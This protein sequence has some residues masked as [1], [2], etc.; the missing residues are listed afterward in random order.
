MRRT[1]DFQNVP[2]A[3][4]PSPPLPSPPRPTSILD[5]CSPLP[6]LCTKCARASA[7]AISRASNHAPGDVSWY[8]LSTPRVHTISSTIDP[9]ENRYLGAIEDHAIPGEGTSPPSRCTFEDAIVSR[10]KHNTHSRPTYTSLFALFAV[11]RDIKYQSKPEHP[12]AL[13]SNAIPALSAR[14]QPALEAHSQP[15]TGS[16]PI[17]HLR[18]SFSARVS[19]D[20]TIRITNTARRALPSRRAKRTAPPS[21]LA[22]LFKAARVPR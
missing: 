7:S 14:I 8:V 11:S 20:L 12:R 19:Q 17:A 4:Q 3:F 18:P 1:K 2:L 21:R 15:T 9:I 22:V 10:H 6:P 5:A 16:N 13:Q